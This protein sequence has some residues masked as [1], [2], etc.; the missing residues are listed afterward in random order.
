MENHEVI[1]V[2][3]SEKKGTEKEIEGIITPDW[4]DE[5]VAHAGAG[6]SRSVF[7]I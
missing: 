3:I 6:I 5:G 1:A 7:G 4:G 2:C